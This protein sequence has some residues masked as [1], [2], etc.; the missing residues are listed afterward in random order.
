MTELD[1]FLKK[2]ELEDE[3][4]LRYILRPGEKPTDNQCGVV[5]QRFTDEDDPSKYSLE[6]W[7]YYNEDTEPTLI[8]YTDQRAHSIFGDDDVFSAQRNVMDYHF[9]EEN[10]K[11]ALQEIYHN[12]VIH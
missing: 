9:N 8:F 11:E 3:N 5:V 6:T 10:L 4:K 1:E 12:F 2:Q 7:V